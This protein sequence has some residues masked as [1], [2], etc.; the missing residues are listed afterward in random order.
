MHFWSLNL[1]LSRLSF[2]KNHRASEA[3]KLS[4][5]WHVCSHMSFGGVVCEGFALFLTAETSQHANCWR[6]T[7]LF[8]HSIKSA[9]R[10][11]EYL[12]HRNLYFRFDWLVDFSYAFHWRKSGPG[13][14]E[15]GDSGQRTWTLHFHV[16]AGTSQPACLVGGAVRTGRA[17]VAVACAQTC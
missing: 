12:K 5:V 15:L 1:S 13:R 9:T 14:C 7:I 4:Y 16:L 10:K 8:S 11:S 17:H 3:G 2:W 6:Q